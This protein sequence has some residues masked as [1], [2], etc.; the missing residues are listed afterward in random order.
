MTPLLR[1]ALLASGP[2]NLMGAVLFA[3]PSV[4]LRA[5][6]GVPE[7]PAFYQW[8]LSLWVLAFGVA[9]AQA[10]W[11]GRADNSLLSLGAFGKIVFVVLM[12]GMAWRDEVPVTTAFAS[13]SD[14][15]LAAVF[16]YAWWR[17]AHGPSALARG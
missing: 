14:L 11:H 17:G 6:F 10:G 15:V 16:A 9:Y 4:A 13:L 7:A 5:A 2:L 12:L 1:G 8:T 3:P